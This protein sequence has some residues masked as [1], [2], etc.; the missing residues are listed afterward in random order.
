MGPKGSCF[1]VVYSLSDWQGAMPIKGLV[2][3]EAG[4]TPC[5]T[6]LVTYQKSLLSQGNANKICSTSYDTLL[7]QTSPLETHGLHIPIR[8]S[9]GCLVTCRVMENSTQRVGQVT[10]SVI[11]NFSNFHVRF[12]MGLLPFDRELP[13]LRG[14]IWCDPSFRTNYYDSVP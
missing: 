13:F 9:Q 3:K 10:N 5:G 8:S 4:K 6:P 12:H 1:C 11:K 14:R 2:F 7:P